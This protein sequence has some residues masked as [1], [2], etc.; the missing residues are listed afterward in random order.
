M[1]V[2]VVVAGVAAPGGFVASVDGVET[3][4]TFL[5][6]NGVTED[7]GNLWGFFESKLSDAGV[8]HVMTDPMYEPT[9]ACIID[10][11]STAA[12][13]SVVGDT[14]VVALSGHGVQLRQPAPSQLPFDGLDP[15]TTEVF[16]AKD[17]YLPS[18][19][20][21]AAW[22]AVGYGMTLVTIV[23]CCSSS[24]IPFVRAFDPRDPDIRPHIDGG[25]THI[26]FTAAREGENALSGVAEGEHFGLLSRGIVTAWRDGGRASYRKWFTSAAHHVTRSSHQTPVIR[27]VGPGDDV[28]DSRP[29]LLGS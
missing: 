29:F 12:S 7:V 13:D 23:D 5:R 26:S 11:I 19:Q 17:T 24:G 28:L 8:P 27:T 14:L 18:E 22:A 16:V 25:G 21:R 4:F 9:A 3:P 10:A 15:S 2:R 1:T 20:L 6:A